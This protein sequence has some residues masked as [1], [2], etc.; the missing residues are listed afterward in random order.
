MSTEYVCPCGRKLRIG[1]HHAGRKVQC[2]GC[3]AAL[4]IPPA[5]P[6]APV[7]PRIVAKPPS[8]LPALILLAL[9]VPGLMGAALTA[10]WYLSRQTQRPGEEV[11]ELALIPPDAQ[12]FLRLRVADLW[13]TKAARA[14]FEKALDGAP[15]RPD[16]IARLRLVTGMRPEQ[17]E[18]V[19]FTLMDQEQRLGWTVIKTS[20][21]IDADRVTT[22]IGAA[23][24]GDVTTHAGRDYYTGTDPEGRPIAVCFL[25]ET[26]MVAGPEGGVK[27]CLTRLAAPATTPGGPLSEALS[28]YEQPHQVVGGLD[29]GKLPRQA[30]AL[31]GL[32]ALSA[33]R[34]LLLTVNVS[35]EATIGVRATT[36]SEEEAKRVLG[37]ARSGLGSA[38]LLLLPMLLKGGDEA[39][40]AGQLLKLLGRIKLEPN[41]EH[42][43]ANVQA[44]PDTIAS[45]LVG[46]S[47]TLA[48]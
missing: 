9:L 4:V 22:H 15:N 21:P 11:S 2:P 31:P 16:P 20:Q 10:W 48:R 35:E 41:R 44:D 37:A 27:L 46:L 34:S 42:V 36:G 17:V 3:G 40:V 45:L 32:E 6:P 30:A 39:K 7:S 23:P 33:L 47:G 29:P 26:L 28:F 12:G 19:C 14:A 5:G 38:R 24:R 8:R 43:L 1:E 25:G 13:G 18:R